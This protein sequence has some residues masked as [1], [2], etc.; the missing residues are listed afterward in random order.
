MECYSIYPPGLCPVRQV[1]PI[2]FINATLH[3][4]VGARP[5]HLRFHGLEARATSNFHRLDKRVPQIPE[6]PLNGLMLDFVVGQYRLRGRIPVDQSFAPIDQPVL[7]QLEKRA[8]NGLDAHVVHGKSRPLPVTR[9]AHRL[10]L[11]D[12]AGF[13]LVLPCLHSPDKFIPLEVCPA[14]SLF[15][16]DTLLDDR[17]SGNTG[18]I[19]AGHPQSVVLLHPTEANQD[20]LQR[21]I[22]SMAQVQRCRNVRRG[23]YDRVSFTIFAVGVR[24]G[25]KV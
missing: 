20:V 15:R 7:K 13:V 1:C 5:F 11:L 22:K 8:A 19:G 16:K 3:S 24:F 18:V 23:D 2:S 14:F 10:Q 21:I 6:M 9:A 25:V 17:L 12:N 4:I